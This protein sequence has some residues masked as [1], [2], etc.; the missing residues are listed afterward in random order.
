MGS[1]IIYTIYTNSTYRYIYAFIYMYIS[2]NP[3]QEQPAVNDTA[4]PRTHDARFLH[5]VIKRGRRRE[6]SSNQEKLQLLQFRM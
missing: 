4:C 5:H 3:D 6:S 2:L 1:E